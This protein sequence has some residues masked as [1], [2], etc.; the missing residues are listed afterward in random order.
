MKKQQDLRFEVLKTLYDSFMSGKQKVDPAYIWKGEAL[1]QYTPAILYLAEKGFVSVEAKKDISR[2]EP[3]LRNLMIKADGIDYIEGNSTAIN[4]NF[5]ERVV[6]TLR[7]TLSEMISRSALPEKEQSWSKKA[8]GAIPGAL[9][10]AA[11]SRLL[12][13]GVDKVPQI[14]SLLRQLIL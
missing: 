9:V 4:V 5:D 6:E 11:T 8:T 10:E 2:K 7:E 13:L 1:A 14:V 12:S 3:I